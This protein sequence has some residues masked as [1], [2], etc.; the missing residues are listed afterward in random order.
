MELISGGS[1]VT[2]WFT[3]QLK[4]FH[5]IVNIIHFIIIKVEI[6]V[7]VLIVES[8][9][10]EKH[11]GFNFAA[12]NMGHRSIKYVLT[13]MTKLLVLLQDMIIILPFWRHWRTDVLRVERC[14]YQTIRIIITS[15]STP[16]SRVISIAV[17]L[18]CSI[19]ANMMTFTLN[20]LFIGFLFH[21]GRLL[22]LCFKTIYERLSVMS[23]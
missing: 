23:S 10:D 9:P 17:D 3:V 4:L 21:L 16:G 5:Y 1:K 14:I 2:Y 20:S 13:R 19:N 6:V 18:G 12:C 7:N 8:T 22:C 15:M 11:I